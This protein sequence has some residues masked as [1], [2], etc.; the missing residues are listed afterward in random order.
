MRIRILSLPRS[1]KPT[2]GNLQR[3]FSKLSILHPT[4]RGSCISNI[5]LHLQCMPM[6][7]IR[8]NSPLSDLQA[9]RFPSYSTVHSMRRTVSATRNR[10][11][12][13]H[14][15][16]TLC[17]LY[18]PLC[19]SLTSSLLTLRHYSLIMHQSFTA[20]ITATT[21]ATAAASTTKTGII[22]PSIASEVSV[23]N[24]PPAGVKPP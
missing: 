23:A 19:S 20:T 24:T 11:I 18:R 3:A 15:S 9:T 5:L 10:S 22:H 21:V 7:M 14:C 6:I 13:A 16:S 17:M 8:P 1:T 12:R 4:F 2:V